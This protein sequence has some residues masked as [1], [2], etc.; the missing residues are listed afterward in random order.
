MFKKSILLAGKT[1]TNSAIFVFYHTIYEDSKLRLTHPP[2][3]FPITPSMV[4][5]I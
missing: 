1:K 4:L 2:P 5:K 3:F